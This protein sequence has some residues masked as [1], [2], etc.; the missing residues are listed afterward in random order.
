MDDH[1][2]LDPQDE[3]FIEKAVKSGRYA[4]RA[5]ILCKGLPVVR[6][7]E[8]AWKRLEAELRKGIDS[9]KG[10]KGIPLEEAFA[11]VRATIREKRNGRKDA[12]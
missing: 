3:A 9:L 1:S 5:E 7:R 11:Q 4:S 8:A 2:A 12:A 10:G 6:E